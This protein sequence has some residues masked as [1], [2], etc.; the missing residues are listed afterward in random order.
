MANFYDLTSNLQLLP[1]PLIRI[2]IYEMLK[3]WPI[4]VVPKVFPI[5]LKGAF[6]L[7]HGLN[8]SLFLTLNQDYA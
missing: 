4:F 8:V 7:F 3:F 6:D 1:S 2:Q 5:R